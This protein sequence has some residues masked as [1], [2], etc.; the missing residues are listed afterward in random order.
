MTELGVAKNISK[1]KIFG[2]ERDQRKF[3]L[4]RK[5]CFQKILSRFG[6]VKLMLL[7]LIMKL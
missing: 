1:M 6:I 2:K 3:F 5:N 4:S 7:H